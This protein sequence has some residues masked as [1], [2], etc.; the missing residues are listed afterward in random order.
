MKGIPNREKQLIIDCLKGQGFNNIRY[1]PDGNVPPDILLNDK[2]AI[3]VRRLN[4][5]QIIGNRLRGLEEDEHA[6]N[7]SLTRIMKKVSDKE[8][9]R[10]AY[11]AW[12]FSRPL[13]EWKII[14]KSVSHILEIHKPFIEE[15]RKYEVDENFKLH[16]FPSTHKK[17]F[18]YEFG[19]SSD[20]DSGCL[21][22]DCIYENLKLIIAEK[23]RKIQNYK[24][25]YSEWWL[26]VIDT[27]GYGLTNLDQ[28]QFHSRPR[29]ESQ[30]DRILLVSP[31]D[32]TRFTFLHE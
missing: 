23:E 4:Q 17:Q 32:S 10:S 15:Q 9:E 7:G 28:E 8:F 3:E 5:N 29:I 31:L 26:A 6:L 22:V 16:I 21:V 13:T 12:S 24:Y 30:F 25:K 1:E 19:M 18:Q 27:I 14:K 2:I 11:V 20:S